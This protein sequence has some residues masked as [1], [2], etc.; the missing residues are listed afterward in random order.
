MALEYDP[1]E[2]GWCCAEG[3]PLWLLSTRAPCMTWS[4][5]KCVWPYAHAR[6][7]GDRSRSLMLL[8]NP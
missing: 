1:D 2:D 4:L 6:T 5:L 8:L 7:L 3:Y